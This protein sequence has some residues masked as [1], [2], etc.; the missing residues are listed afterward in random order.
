MVVLVG[1]NVEIDRAKEASVIAH[2]QLDLDPQPV[3]ADSGQTEPEGDLGR[4]QGP[5]DRGFLISD[6]HLDSSVDMNSQSVDASMTRP[7]DASNVNDAIS[8]MDM[9]MEDATTDAVLDGAL[10][11]APCMTTADCMD[12]N[13]CVAEQ[14]VPLICPACRQRDVCVQGCCQA[15]TG[16]VE[17]CL[18][19]RPLILDRPL[20]MGT[21]TGF[22]I[23]DEIR[24]SCDWDSARDLFAEFTPDET[25]T[26]CL[27]GDDCSPPCA[28]F[29][30]LNCCVDR[31]GVAPSELA[32][33]FAQPGQAI[34]IERILH[35]DVSY[36]IGLESTRPF[37]L[38]NAGIV[39]MRRGPCR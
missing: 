15:A 9:G 23:I 38:A 17:S 26:Y 32:C 33:E 13:D 4:I 35:A 36:R 7:R 29:V 24:P 27:H 1:C 12:G 19:P 25:G 34:F 31:A 18:S 10:A 11:L 14:C 21:Q 20:R 2:S 8:R 28:L 16:T 37:F 30:L 3:P 39:T 22:N 5:Q 6:A